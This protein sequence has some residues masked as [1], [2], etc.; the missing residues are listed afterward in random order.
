VS[1]RDWDRELAKIDRKL[2]RTSDE[3]L[4]PTPR[5]ASP[6]AAAQTAQVRKETTTFGVFARLLLAVALGVGMLFWPYAARCGPGLA[7]YL[8]ATA[9]VVGAG[10]WTAVW[11][12]RHRSGR[13]HVLALLLV[14]W[15]IAL[16]AI[17]ILP[18]AGYAVPTPERPAAWS[19]GA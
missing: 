1:D 3:A 19:C 8:A 5:G 9:V 11:T 10:V 17:E 13:A 15:G 14:V 18:R 7:G 6:A 16:A 2:E 4:L 12:W